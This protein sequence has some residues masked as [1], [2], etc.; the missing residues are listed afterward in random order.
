MRLLGV[1]LQRSTALVKHGDSLSLISP[2]EHI[3]APTCFHD[4]GM[5]AAV[6]HFPEAKVW[7]VSGMKKML[8]GLKVHT[9]AVNHTPDDWRGYIEILP[10]CGMP[11]VNEHV[12]WHAE[13][14]TLLTSDLLFNI[15]VD[16][17]IWTKLFFRFNGVWQKPGPTRIFRYFIEDKQ[18]F[19]TSIGKLAALPIQK[20]LPSHGLEITEEKRIAE[21]LARL[22]AL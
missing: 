17:D 5:R 20:I 8:K 9:L 21:I 13:S 7:A 11:R 15:S 16:A 14:R 3:I 10:I 1:D 12:L 2:T 18:A 6:E 22:G 4:T 19:R